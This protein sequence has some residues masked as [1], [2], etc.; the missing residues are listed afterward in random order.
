M[1]VTS[2][3]HLLADNPMQLYL[4]SHIG[5]SGN[6]FCQ[7]CNIGGTQEHKQTDEG[8]HKLFESGELCTSKNTVEE[9]KGQLEDSVKEL[10]VEDRQCQTGVKD[11]L[12]EPIHAE[13]INQHKE[14]VKKH[15]S[16][17]NDL[18]APLCSL[19]IKKELHEWLDRQRNHES[20][21]LCAWFG[22]KLRYPDRVAPHCPVGGY[23]IYQE[24]YMIEDC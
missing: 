23:Q 18:Y 20:S 21:S 5:L 17:G 15:I 16:L 19:G 8:Y 3:L 24:Y 12:T 4:C 22:S 2:V 13:P 10:L 7:E 6:H 1:I 11:S 14:L 9:I